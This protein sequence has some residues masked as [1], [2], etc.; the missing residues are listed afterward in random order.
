LQVFRGYTKPNYDDFVILTVGNFIL[1]IWSFKVTYLLISIVTE[2][3]NIDHP[4][5]RIEIACSS[6]I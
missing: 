5:L 1:H 2:N 3:T 4:M 6:Q